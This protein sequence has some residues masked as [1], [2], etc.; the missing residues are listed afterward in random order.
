MGKG[1]DADLRKEVEM[2]EHQIT[3]EELARQYDLNLSTGLND[4]E[5]KKVK[6]K[7]SW[8]NFAVSSFARLFSEVIRAGDKSQGRVTESFFG[9]KEFWLKMTQKHAKKPLAAFERTHR[10]INW[11]LNFLNFMNRIY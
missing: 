7:Q 10:K 11:I 1:D 4:A 6:K 8:W 2:N 9:V 3:I 5:A